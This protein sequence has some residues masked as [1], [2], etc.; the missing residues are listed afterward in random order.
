MNILSNKWWPRF[1]FPLSR[2][3][4]AIIL[5]RNK[6]Y[7]WNIFRTSKIQNC[8]VISVGNIS[9]GGTGKT[10]AVE[11][12]AKYLISRA[13]KTAILSR[14]YRRESSGTLLISDGQKILVGPQRSG[15]EPYLLA[16][17]LPIV[18][19]V[20][21]NDRYRG[22]IFI[23]QK[24]N[25]DYLILDDAYQHRRIFRDIDIVLIDSMIGLSNNHTLPGGVLR[26]PL[27]G[28]NRADMIWLTRV[29]QASKVDSLISSIRKY[30]GVP[31]IKTMHEPQFLY[32][33]S[34]SKQ[35][36]LEL[37]KNREIFIFS[38]IGNPGA[39]RDTVIRLQ[40]NVRG[41]LLFSDHH[42]YRKSDFQKIYTNAKLSKAE[43]IITTEKDAIRIQELPE[44]NTPIYYLKIELK[45]IEGQKHLAKILGM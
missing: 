40:A 39:F 9:V 14:G 5:L 29:N 43:W 27:K 1:F 23:K 21:E 44:M 28:L 31:I 11:F 33:L 2:I 41:E 10:P 16:K 22:G 18:P 26:E 42:K 32:S 3:Y 6:L 35:I 4:A 25:P 24:F 36:S 15:D 20:V 17:N 13:K 37:L 34:S 12:L 19:V 30:T 38:G 7:D 8:T 45:I